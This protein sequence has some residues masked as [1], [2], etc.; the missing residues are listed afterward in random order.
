MASLHPT[1]LS[2]LEHGK[3]NGFV[4][5]YHNLATALG[6]SLSELVDVSTDLEVGPSLRE[7][8]NLLGKVKTLDEKKRAVFLDAAVKLYEKIE[9]I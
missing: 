3:V 5:N 6:I 9:T 8:Q 4:C 1:S 2:D 7:L